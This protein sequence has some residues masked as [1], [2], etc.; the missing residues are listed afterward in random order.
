MVDW[1]V[2]WGVKSA[3]SF[4]FK[5]V[6]LPLSKGGIEDYVKESLKERIKGVVKNE[7]RTAV[8][9]A[10]TEFLSLIQDELQG[11]ED[12][13]TLAQ[14]ETQFSGAVKEFVYHPDI[15]SLLGQA[16]GLDGD[17]IDPDRLAQIWKNADLTPLPLDFRWRKV[18]KVYR[19]KVRVILA[20]SKE[21]RSLLDSQNLDE[22]RDLVSND[23]GVSVPDLD[24]ACYREALQECYGYLRLSVLD[25][26]DSQHRIKLWS[27]FIAQQVKE[28]TPSSKFDLPKSHQQRLFE[29]GDLSE[30]MASQTH[31][32]KY[33][34]YL[35][36]PPCLITELL[37]DRTCRYATILGDPGAGKSAWFQYLALN[38]VENPQLQE[39]IPLLLEL[40]K[41]KQDRSGANSFLDFFHQSPGAFH[42]LNRL[43]LDRRLRSG[44]VRVLFDGLDEIFDRQLRSEATAEIISFTNQYPQV[45]VWVT[46]RIIGYNSERLSHAGFRHFTIQDFGDEEIEEF[47]VKWHEVALDHEHDRN[48][49]ADRLRLAIA[50]SP[51]IKELAGNPL[52]LTMMAILNLRQELPRDRVN[53][54]E[55]ASLVLLHSW[56][57]EYHELPQV[58]EILDRQGKQALLKQIAYKMQSAPAGFAGNSISREDLIS[59]ISQ[60]LRERE[61]DKPRQV[62]EKLI[63]QLRTRNFI[64][65]YVG[66][67][68]YTFMHRTF[69]EYFCASYFV[70]QFEKRRKLSLEDL[71]ETV[72]R[73]HWQNATWHEVLRL[74]VAQIDSELAGKI[75]EWLIEQEDP[76]QECTNIFLA[77]E[78]LLDVKERFKIPAVENNIIDRLKVI[79]TDYDLDYYYFDD[80]DDSGSEMCYSIQTQAVYLIRR[81]KP[82]QQEY[83]HRLEDLILSGVDR[84]I[85]VSLVDGFANGWN[86]QSTKN[87]FTVVRQ[88]SEQD[89]VLN[90]IVRGQIGL[91]FIDETD[92]K[93]IRDHV[94][95][96]NLKSMSIDENLDEDLSNFAIGQLGR[97]WNDH[98]ETLPLIKNTAKS[99][100]RKD[101]RIAAISVIAQEYRQDPNTWDFIE[102]IALSDPDES[103]RSNTVEVI[104]QGWG[105]DLTALALILNIARSD[106]HESVRCA[107]VR[108][109]GTGW[110]TVNN[111]DSIVEIAKFAPHPEVRCVAVE[112]IS[113]VCQDDNPMLPLLMEIARA[114]PDES[115]RRAAVWAIT[116]EWQSDPTSLPLLMEISQSDPNFFVRGVTI[117]AIANGWRD[118]EEILEFITKII[119]SDAHEE[120]RTYAISAFGSYRQSDPQTFSLL[121]N[122]AQNEP[123]ECVRS[124]AVEEIH[125]TALDSVEALPLLMSLARLDPSELVRYWA[126][127]GIIESDSQNP[128]TLQLLVD[129]ARSDVDDDIRAIALKEISKGYRDYEGRFELLCDRAMNDP[130]IKQDEEDETNPRFVA[131]FALARQYPTRTETVEILRDRAMNDLDLE[132]REFATQEL[133]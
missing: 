113:K 20:E 70:E 100:S 3:A 77:A 98:S 86:Q 21:L 90:F 37:V 92:L 2:A 69:L 84:D 79:A 33:Y 68:I 53:L 8:G 97:K 25:S 111:L 55:Q 121:A 52:L 4:A 5:E 7:H 127:R 27:V 71:I 40:G 82:Q 14:I 62:A 63:E 87:F 96:G 65:C 35:E 39:P 29:R 102:T 122:L 72:Y 119:Q 76:A 13:L 88:S 91:E 124:S 54:Y 85:Q 64:L 44:Q 57:I 78:C 67:D 131:L 103:V 43:D 24:E 75:I 107:A 81:L 26:T 132:I 16:F 130:F 22:I 133:K 45:P 74:I 108:A 114:D 117:W 12:D 36:R 41:Y 34:E 31:N 46:S 18:V 30:S 109:I 128:D 104:G 48:R 126:I 32:Q 1:L 118:S 83:L 59:E 73:P 80:W 93:L 95:F 110:P 61:V 120:V 49:F 11:A 15:K 89:Y 23:A 47:I 112:L 116:N 38:W 6:L 115:V 9:K 66:A 19:Q 50:Q 60:F 106:R 56:D 105:E 42:K 28:G 99:D 51:A 17:S 125:N 58:L 94:S 123:D 129:R 101:V 10:L